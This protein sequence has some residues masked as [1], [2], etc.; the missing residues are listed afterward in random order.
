[1][2]IKKRRENM[3][4]RTGD[5]EEESKREQLEMKKESIGKGN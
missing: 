1:M 5:Q 2:K 4:R 3:G